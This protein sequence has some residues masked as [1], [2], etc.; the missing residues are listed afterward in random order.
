MIEVSNGKYLNTYL[1]PIKD[2][3]HISKMFLCSTHVDKKTWA[4]LQDA[5]NITLAPLVLSPTM[6]TIPPIRLPPPA[7]R[8]PTCKIK[9]I[10]SVSEDQ[11][12]CAIFVGLLGIPMVPL[13]PSPVLD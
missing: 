7:P 12:E 1:I 9:I 5:S 10:K 4:V 13:L 2:M 6:G 3:I 11:V 8:P